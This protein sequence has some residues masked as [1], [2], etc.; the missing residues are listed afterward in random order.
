[1]ITSAIL[2]LLIA[3]S[4]MLTQVQVDTNVVT[5]R[6]EL[7]Q[8]KRAENKERIQE[9]RN[10]RKQKVVSNIAARFSHVKSKWVANWTRY[11]DRL[12]KI[13][14]KIEQE[15]GSFDSLE[16][17]NAS[18][19][20]ARDLVEAMENKEYAIE[21]ES[22]ETLREDIKLTVDEFKSDMQT[23]MASVRQAK[24]DLQ[25]AFTEVR[26]DSDEGGEDDE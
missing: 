24:S 19:Q 14:E 6:R 25:A 1:M 10:D 22:E 21:F 23:T 7:I 9:I 8:Q 12:E 16:V 15:F 11:L 18:I 20:E 4:S 2:T 13:S 26:V 3:S 5:D 17:A